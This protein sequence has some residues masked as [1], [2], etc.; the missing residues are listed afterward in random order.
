MKKTS[1]TGPQILKL[2][3][4]YKDLDTDNDGY[5]DCDLLLEMPELSVNPLKRRIVNMF[6]TKETQNGQISFKKFMIALS[7]LCENA[8][9]E[10]KIDF[11]FRLYDVN[12]DGKVC[13]SDLRVIIKLLVGN[14]MSEDYITNLVRQTMKDADRNGDSEITFE[15]FQ[16]SIAN[17]ISIEKILTMIV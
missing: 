1:F 15:E 12:R 2:F 6:D 17:S 3:K 8:T 16:S 14:S 7:P 9:R 4:R 11:A 10:E 13:Q 5:I